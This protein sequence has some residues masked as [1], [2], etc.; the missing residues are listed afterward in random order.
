[1]AS[2]PLL[3][4]PPLLILRLTSLGLVTLSLS[5]NDTC[6]DLWINSIKEQRS[7]QGYLYIIIISSYLIQLVHNFDSRCCSCWLLPAILCRAS[8]LRIWRDLKKVFHCFNRNWQIIAF[9]SLTRINMISAPTAE[10]ICVTTPRG[11]AHACLALSTRA[12]QNTATNSPTDLSVAS[13][14][15]PK[16]EVRSQPRRRPSEAAQPTPSSKLT[17]RWPSRLY[18]IG[19]M[20]EIWRI[21]SINWILFLCGSL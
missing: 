12:R 19:P 4:K 3:L 15:E 16:M 17:A 7:I 13:S 5:C 2:H 21:I 14:P 10:L 6:H 20:L 9:T 18:V 1:M 11:A 8:A